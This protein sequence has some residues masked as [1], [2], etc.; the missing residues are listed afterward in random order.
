MNMFYDAHDLIDEKMNFCSGDPWRAERSFMVFGSR[1][2]ILYVAVAPVHTSSSL[3]LSLTVALAGT[4]ALVVL[5]V[6]SRA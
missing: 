5:V 6:N 1:Q 4:R 3:F 2:R